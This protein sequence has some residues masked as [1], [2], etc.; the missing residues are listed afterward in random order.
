MAR[1]SRKIGSKRRKDPKRDWT[2]KLESG[3][4]VL[5]ILEVIVVLLFV[6]RNV[7]DN[8]DEARDGYFNLLEV[9]IPISLLIVLIGVEE[10][11]FSILIG[12]F[13]K[14]LAD[15]FRFLE[16]SKRGA[17]T[18]AIVAFT[19]A[20]ILLAP[21]VQ[22]MMEDASGRDLTETSPELFKNFKSKDPL[23]LTGLDSMFVGTEDN[24]LFNVTLYRG[25]TLADAIV[26]ANASRVREWE[27]N[28]DVDDVDDFIILAQPVAAEG[29][30]TW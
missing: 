5:Y 23:N 9:L 19:L 27:H 1:E 12:A 24:I 11:L 16:A 8:M 18:T 20:F 15:R 25:D 28:F 10:V 2:N 30:I 29:D 6:I 13:R 7:I 4:I 26:E 3:K 17:M 14:D 21:P 22:D